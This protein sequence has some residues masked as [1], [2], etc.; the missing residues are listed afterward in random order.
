MN[1]L[2][3]NSNDLPIKSMSNA[4]N[5][6][7]ALEKQRKV[8]QFRKENNEIV[9]IKPCNDGRF[10]VLECEEDSDILHRITFKDDKKSVAKRLYQL[11]KY[12]NQKYYWQYL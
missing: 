7:E 4:K 11:R 1:I 8:I 6:L 3:I 9:Q 5:I 2:I 12:F 10:A